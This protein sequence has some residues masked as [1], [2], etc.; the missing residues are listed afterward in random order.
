[1]GPLE[2][3]FL[4]PAVC[5]GDNSIATE[6]LLFSLTFALFPSQKSA[7]GTQCHYVGTLEFVDGAPV[8]GFVH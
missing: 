6:Y 5:S 3:M 1:M 4:G 8:L 2:S 7:S